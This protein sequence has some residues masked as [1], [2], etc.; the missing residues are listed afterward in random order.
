MEWLLSSRYQ[1]FN[2]LMMSQIIFDVT[3]SPGLFQ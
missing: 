2:N 3:T 1:N